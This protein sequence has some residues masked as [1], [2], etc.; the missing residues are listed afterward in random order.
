MSTPRRLEWAMHAFPRRFRAQR[1]AEIEATFHE[2]DLAG[3][4][5]AYGPAALAD[6]VI[7]GWGERARTR[8]PF[9]HYLKYRLLGG[10]LEPRWHAW[11]FDDLGG[12]FAV[13]RSA[14]V[15]VP[16]CAILTAAWLGSDGSMPLPP[17]AIAPVWIIAMGLG[18]RLDRRR[19]LTRHGY[20][21]ATRT[22]MPPTMV[23][24]VP[25]VRRIR[26]AVP[27]LVG[28]AAALLVVTPFAAITLLFPDLA[29][30]SVTI[31]SS[32]FERTVD[33]SVVFGLIAVAVGFIGLAVG[34]AKHRWIASHSLVASKAVEPTAFIVIPAGP[35][36]WIAPG[37]VLLVG[38]ATSLFPLAPLVV[39]A[40]FLAA[41][42]ASPGLLLLAHSAH[43]LERTGSGD[44]GLSLA[45]HHAQ[46]RAF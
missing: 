6:V 4:P 44:V 37:C 3:D 46:A 35:W 36:A 40:M 19:T 30:R 27:I 14:W 10:R 12:W 34:V 16:L 32:S 24:W 8:P 31:G 13:R 7:A 29:V 22:W 28:I 11:M 26:R 45:P 1:S 15:L 25:T 42:C 18:A 20:D 23:Q 5:H 41:G 2:A 21:P 38:I 33:H 9:G 43:R 17:P 39:P